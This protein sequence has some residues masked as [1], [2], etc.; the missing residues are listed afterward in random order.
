MNK[1]AKKKEKEEDIESKKF[2]LLD[3]YV[4]QEDVKNVLAPS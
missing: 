3:M 2:A 4:N 1:T